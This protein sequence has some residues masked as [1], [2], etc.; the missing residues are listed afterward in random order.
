MSALLDQLRAR[1]AEVWQAAT[2]L[3]N[4]AAENGGRAFTADE[5]RN[6]DLANSELDQLDERIKSLLEGDRRAADTKDI[7]DRI[8]GVG[9]PN[10]AARRGQ[11]DA[12]LERQFR[13][14]VADRNPT[15]ISCALEP[16]TWVPAQEEIET[17]ALLT[18]EGGAGAP[19]VPKT[20]LDRIV[21]FWLDQSGVLAAGAT[22]INSP[23][24]GELTISRHATYASAGVVAEGPAH[25][26]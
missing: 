10:R 26:V 4:R 6:F 13:A 16:R 19:L 11:A 8:N 24:G 9:T 21:H 23:D 3:A 5:Q 25:P 15:P 20:F 22:V 17:R 14:A 2:D 1:R 7:F 12:D 18:S